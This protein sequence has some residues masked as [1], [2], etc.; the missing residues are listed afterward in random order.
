MKKILRVLL[1]VIFIAAVFFVI[2]APGDFA[3][4][5]YGS[6]LIAL[7]RLIPSLFLMMTLSAFANRSGILSGAIKI[8]SPIMRLY[9]LPDDAFAALFW[10][11]ISGFP[12]GAKTA[13]ELYADKRLT[14][15]ETKNL[16]TFCN[17]CS[18]GFVLGTLGIIY[19]KKAG[20][21]LFSVQLLSALYI[22]FIFCLKQ[23]G[24]RIAR[25][26][27][28]HESITASLTRAITGSIHACIDLTS[29]LLFSSIFTVFI[30]RL[31]L[32]TNADAF[33]GGL[34]ELTGGILKFENTGRM[35]L[36]LM[37]FL[38]SFGGICV[39]LQT[40][41][42]CENYGISAKK[43]ICAKFISGCFSF[44]TAYIFYPVVFGD[45][46]SLLPFI[47]IIG[48]VLSVILLHKLYKKENGEINA[49]RKFREK[50]FSYRRK[51]ERGHRLYG[52]QD[53]NNAA[54]YGKVRPDILRRC[55]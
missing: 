53:I 7:K 43:Y 29:F 51:N 15:K 39:I 50:S 21:F 25:H 44:I 12:I 17:N 8:C 35:E 23:K 27:R 41:S 34:T 28:R 4:A 2:Y 3:D 45:L 47:F 13:C 55:G 30:S 20:I 37:A 9:G 48:P 36:S 1:V 54:E 10:G 49:Y 40:A 5:V 11:S 24:G 6:L 32:N 22:G 19:G 14:K 18:P 31:P 42:I 33:L 16:L 38:L 26:E 46:F 52:A